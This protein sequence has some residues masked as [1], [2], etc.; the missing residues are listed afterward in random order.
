MIA[1]S[2]TSSRSGFTLVNM[3]V[4]MT[5]LGVVFAVGTAALV[6]AFRTEKA[7]NAA[8]RRLAAHTALAD[9]F[10]ADVHQAR[11]LREAIEEWEAGPTCLIL[12][13]ADDRHVIYQWQKGELQRIE[14]PGPDAQ[15]QRVVVGPDCAGVEF[16]RDPQKSGLVTLR[17]SVSR[18]PGNAPR[19]LDITAAVGGDRR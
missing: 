7:T 19:R 2:R 15:T 3:L 10:R 11:A 4:L 17:L 14:Q 9:T 12:R 13:M 8:S 16:L 5:A 18:G 1:C 6:G